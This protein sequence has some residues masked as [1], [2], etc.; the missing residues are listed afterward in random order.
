MK[1]VLFVTTN[2]ATIPGTS[3]PTGVWLSG[4]A[5]PY[6]DLVQAGYDVHIAS[7]LGG[8]VP[9]DPFSNP[10][11][12]RSVTRDD[13]V[14]HG[15]LAAP[16]H[17]CKLAET[18]KLSA[19]DP[20][21]YRALLICGGNGAMFDLPGDPDL[22][23]I[24]RGLWELG[25][26][27]AAISH[28]VAGLIDVKLAG[29]KPL[30]A[31]HKVTAI[32]REDQLIAEH[33]VGKPYY[34]FSFE[35]ALPARAGATYVKANAY[36]PHVVASAGGRLLTGQGHNSADA[37]AERI[38]AAL[39]S[40]APVEGAK[41]E[42]QYEP[43]S[44]LLSALNQYFH[45]DYEELVGVTRL[46]LEREGNPVLILIGNELVLHRN[47][48]REVTQVIPPVYH[49]LKAVGHMLFG[50][51]LSLIV[52]EPGGLNERKLVQVEQQHNLINTVLDHLDEQ[53]F[54]GA[55][56]AGQRVLLGAA[57]QI[58]A[59][60]RRTRR[61]DLDAVH[62]FARAMGKEMSENTRTAQRAELT[63][64]H[65]KVCVW[66]DAMTPE[67][68]ERLFVVVCGS[69]QARYQEI[70][71]TYFRHLLGEFSTHGAH[72]EDRLMYAESKFEEDSGIDL[73]A[74]HIIDQDAGDAFFGDRFRM[75]RDLLGDG[76]E[77]YINDL[78]ASH[79]FAR[80]RA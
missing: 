36:S 9:I 32:S 13:I 37:L 18:E 19:I 44:G 47:G 33:L 2:V 66:L 77:A 52:R 12:E 60:C 6:F 62:A 63:C 38:A 53:G 75:Q 23:R 72:G 51:Y 69:H 35:D 58:L 61:V 57:S 17:G 7:P 40:R 71:M 22:E 3:T 26:V 14:T 68:R 31:G 5:H 39:T 74:R 64:L 80:A 25:R 10:A 27:I 15:F 42:A 59:E 73:I 56:R 54:S 67:E 30:L 11:S 55:V 78:L 28:G 21:E 20:R 1:R 8:P 4:V 65:E 41:T 70:A 50:V 49:Q 29:G 34:P 24:A 46:S 16:H 43:S 76:A 79:P 48:L 45:N